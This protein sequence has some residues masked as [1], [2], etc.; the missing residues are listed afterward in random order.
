[1]GRQNSLAFSVILATPQV[2][3]DSPDQKIKALHYYLI[4][5]MVQMGGRLLNH[6]ERIEIRE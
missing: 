4:E 5:Y 1:M 6:H 3:Q 2:L